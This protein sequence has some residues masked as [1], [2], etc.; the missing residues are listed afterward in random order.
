MAESKHTPGPWKDWSDSTRLVVAQR[1][2]DSGAHGVVA[3]MAAGFGVEQKEANARLIAAAPELLDALKS[4]L[5]FLDFCDFTD[6]EWGDS[7]GYE[8]AEKARA[9]IAKVED[10]G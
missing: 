3:T 2:P 1:S 5:A 4:A 7:E 9:V 10:E 8:V 6:P